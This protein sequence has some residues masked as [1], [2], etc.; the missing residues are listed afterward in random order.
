MACEVLR[1]RDVRRDCVARPAYNQQR[2]GYL[3]ECGDEPWRMCMRPRPVR[4]LYEL[5]RDEHAINSVDEACRKARASRRQ[6][7]RDRVDVSKRCVAHFHFSVANS[8]QPPASDQLSSAG[9][10]CSC[11][12]C[13]RGGQHSSWLRRTL[14]LDPLTACGALL[15]A[16]ARAVEVYILLRRPPRPIASATPSNASPTS[17]APYD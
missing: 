13:G 12:T 8:H 16:A 11:C 10:L 2:R 5:V 14:E 3:L 6:R 1:R 9:A 17:R 4:D 15:T 7:P